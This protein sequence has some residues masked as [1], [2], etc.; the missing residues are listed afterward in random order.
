MVPRIALQTTRSKETDSRVFIILPARYR[1]DLRLL[2][3]ASLRRKPPNGLGIG[4][5]G[6]VNNVHLNKHSWASA[7]I[8]TR[9][10][11]PEACRDGGWP[12]AGGDGSGTNDC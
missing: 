1:T 6:H 9:A 3:S 8:R 11:R 7:S 10:G 2:N 12:V 4:C 5:R